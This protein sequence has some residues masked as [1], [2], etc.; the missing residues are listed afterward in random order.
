[1]ASTGACAQWIGEQLDRA[2]RGES[3]GVRGRSTHMR[4]RH[5]T[6]ARRHLVGQRDYG[7]RHLLNGGG[8]K[9]DGRERRTT[10]QMLQ[11][12]ACSAAV[13]IRMQRT[14]GKLG[15]VEMTRVMRA[16]GGMVVVLVWPMRRRQNHP[17]QRSQRRPGERERRIREQ[18]RV[19]EMPAGLSRTH[20]AHGI[21]DSS[22]REQHNTRIVPRPSLQ[23]PGQLQCRTMLGVRMRTP[24]RGN[25]MGT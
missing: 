4:Q 24:I 7:E 20:D 2:E 23:C 22:C 9:R 1:M 5:A 16:R 19:Q 17:R 13:I 6:G 11:E 12:L 10:R 14:S 25:E 21:V 8:R 3:G 15:R 18:R